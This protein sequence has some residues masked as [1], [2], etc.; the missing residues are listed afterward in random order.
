MILILVFSHLIA[1]SF[2]VVDNSFIG[3]FQ[4]LIFS[5]NQILRNM[6]ENFN[7]FYSI[8]CETLGG[9]ERIFY[10]LLHEKYCKR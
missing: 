6:T 4:V 2:Q 8:V 7:I 3:G 1:P 5:Q 10:L 9:I